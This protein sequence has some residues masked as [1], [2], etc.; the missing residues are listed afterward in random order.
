MATSLLQ[1]AHILMLRERTHW[2]ITLRKFKATTGD[3]VLGD[4][5][6]LETEL[7]FWKLHLQIPS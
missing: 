7:S 6:I 3:A 1:C 4:I 2:Q 5:A